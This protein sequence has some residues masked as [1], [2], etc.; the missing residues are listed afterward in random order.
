MK[1]LFNKKSLKLY[2]GIFFIIAGMSGVYTT[3]PDILNFLNNDG[4]KYTH[5][6]HITFTGDAAFAMTLALF[7]ASIIFIL[8]GINYFRKSSEAK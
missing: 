7:L 1:N 6:D 2:L 4:I 5:K 3:I 8:L